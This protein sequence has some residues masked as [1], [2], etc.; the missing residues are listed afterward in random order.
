MADPTDAPADP[1]VLAVG[2]TGHRN[3]HPQAMAAL[4][5][6]VVQAFERLEKAFSLRLVVLSSLAEGADRLVAE[7]A[8]ERGH[9][10]VAP[11]PL[12][13]EEYEKDFADAASRAE[14][15]K[16]LARAESHFTVPLPSGDDVTDKAV[17]DAAYRR[18]GILVARDCHLLLALWDGQDSGK[19]GG[20]WDVVRIKRTGDEGITAAARPDRPEVQRG[21]V[22][23]IDTPRVGAQKPDAVTTRWPDSS[24]QGW[25][26][27]QSVCA[28]TRRFN[29]DATALQARAPGAIARSRASLHI[30]DLPTGCPPALGGLARLF[31]LADALASE[32]QRRVR[33]AWRLLYSLGLLAVVVFGYYAHGA[34]HN[35]W[36]ALTGYL[37]TVGAAWL[38]F[39]RFERSERHGRF[40]DY[41]AMAEALRVLFFWRAANLP[42]DP[43]V[44]Y[45]ANLAAEVEWVRQALRLEAAR[46]AD[47][48]GAGAAPAARVDFAVK[49]WVLPQRDFYR[50]A[51][52]RDVRR[53]KTVHHWAMGAI[54]AGVVLAAIVLLLNIV[55]HHAL[56]VTYKPIHD[57][58][59][60]LLPLLPAIGATLF[61][62][63]HRMGW[64]AQE[65]QYERIAAMFEPAVE[66]LQAGPA[67]LAVRQEIVARL[68]REALAEHAQWVLLHRQRPFEFIAGGG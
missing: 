44:G 27:L 26:R 18:A 65:R 37:A 41:R 31:A 11:L 36:L 46:V 39:R 3:P 67:D 59:L 48:G 2:V 1:L 12:P 47:F 64:E 32:N 29:G 38:M 49:D 15:R 61:S 24:E 42:G 28:L 25:R 13:A 20:T 51:R 50:A 7:I 45:S 21:V 22:V 62:F 56:L 5:S 57:W 8:L 10:L 63:A 6:H 35:H 30:E 43:F 52:Q 53:L 16:L 9:K 34:P 68:A 40:L 54:I 17:R 33:Q 19:S 60:I 23:H 55:D 4:R 58:T 66:A 14:F